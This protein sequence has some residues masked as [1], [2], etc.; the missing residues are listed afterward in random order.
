MQN[1]LVRF[2]LDY[3]GRRSLFPEDFSKIGILNVSDRVKQL[4]LGHV[5]NIHKGKAP[6][7][8]SQGFDR[9]E[10]RYTTRSSPLNFTVSQAKGVGVNTFYYNGVRDWNSLPHEAKSANCRNTFKLLVK[11]YLSNQSTLVFNDPFIFY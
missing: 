5:F 4:R 9:A 2:V 1:K 7:F 6:V 8:L 3:N 11:H 10:R